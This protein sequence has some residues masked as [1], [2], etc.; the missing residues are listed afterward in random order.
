[1][2]RASL[3]LIWFAGFVYAG[4]GRSVEIAVLPGHLEHDHYRFSVLTRQTSKGAWF[5]VSVTSK[6]QP[7]TSDSE[8]GLSI[9]IHEYDDTGLSSSVQ[10]V[11]PHVP[12]KVT[13]W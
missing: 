11:I 13:K 5:R 12:I 4:H 2:F 10:E 8:V 9:V 7:I 3:I 1:M 6:S